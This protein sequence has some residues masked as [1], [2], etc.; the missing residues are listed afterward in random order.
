MAITARKQIFITD[1]SDKDFVCAGGQLR[2]KTGSFVNDETGGDAPV[3]GAAPDNPPTNPADGAIVVEL[4][5]DLRRIWS[6]SAA[7]G[8]YTHIE[9]RFYYLTFSD[10]SNTFDAALG[11]SV[12]IA[13]ADDSIEVDA[14]GG[15]FDVNLKIVF[16]RILHTP[17]GDVV[18]SGG[19]DDFYVVPAEL[20]GWELDS[21]TYAQVGGVGGQDVR[22][23]LEG[24]PV[25]SVESLSGDS[26]A[27]DT[28]IGEAVAAGDV[29][30]LGSTVTSGSPEGLSATFA[31]KK[32]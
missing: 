19:S 31:F 3:V 16:G 2:V 14:S 9:D 29:I 30:T 27:T 15:S 28:G 18:S 6:F 7:S 20:D 24:S 1:I 13:S 21:A 12:E 17:S 10:S 8:T 25:G 32:V 22:L 4:F 23:T 26:H 5:D 11:G